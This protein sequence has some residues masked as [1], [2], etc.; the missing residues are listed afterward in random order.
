MEGKARF[1]S[2][3]GG[4]QINF[5]LDT[6]QITLLACVCVALAVVLFAGGVVVGRWYGAAAVKPLPDLAALDEE[7]TEQIPQA[8]TLSFH[9]RLA[10]PPAP[11]MQPAA[12]K[13]AEEEEADTDLPDLPED[14]DPIP[15]KRRTEAPLA[16]SSKEKEKEEKTTAAVKEAPPEKPAAPE[17]A[18]EREARNAEETPSRVEGEG[19][20]TLQAGSFPSKQEAEALVK[21]LKAKGEAPYLIH[22]KVSGMYLV[23]VGAFETIE[24]AKKA[25]QSLSA[26]AG[27]NPVI[28]SR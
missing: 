23:R 13:E 28:S 22:S 7:A 15:P 4:R 27:L 11:V 10:G 2:G 25:K 1:L 8:S 9:E 21:K 5:S 14:Q 18:P 6:R 26:R 19:R 24:E 16:D 17:R 20:F 12:R 3:P